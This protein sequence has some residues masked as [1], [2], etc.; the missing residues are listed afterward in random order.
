MQWHARGT[1]RYR[2][3]GW[4]DPEAANDQ[5]GDVFGHALA[6]LVQFDCCDGLFIS[7]RGGIAEVFFMVVFSFMC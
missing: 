2:Q 4:L 6:E 3:G 5:F 1:H 7:V